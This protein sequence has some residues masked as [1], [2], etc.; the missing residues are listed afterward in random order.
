MVPPPRPRPAAPRWSGRAV[1][2]PRHLRG[3][4]RGARGGGD[5]PARLVPAARQHPRPA[6]RAGAEPGGRALPM[7]AAGAGRTTGR[8]PRLP[9]GPDALRAAPA[10]GLARGHHHARR[11]LPRAAAPLLRP[12]G[13]PDG[14]RHGL[15]ARVAACRAQ[16]GRRDPSAVV[17]DRGGPG[18]RGPALRVA[19]LGGRVRDRLPPGGHASQ[20]GGKLR[21]APRPGAGLRRRRPGGGL[22]VPRAAARLLSRSHRDARPHRAPAVRRARARAIRGGSHD[23]EQLGAEPHGE[24]SVPRAAEAIDPAQVVLV[25][26]AARH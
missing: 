21:S 9:A 18:P 10:A 24:T 8:G 22:G 2:A 14:A 6:D 3:Q 16:E 26:R 7:G 23:R 5:G 11:V 12:G 20:R 15:V 4:P 1:V 17:R 19:G 13:A 25:R